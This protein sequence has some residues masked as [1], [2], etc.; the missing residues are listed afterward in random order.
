MKISSEPNPK[1]GIPSEPNIYEMFSSE[2]RNLQNSNDIL[3]C[4]GG[5]EWGGP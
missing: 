1:N 3:L 4:G 5:R 2:P